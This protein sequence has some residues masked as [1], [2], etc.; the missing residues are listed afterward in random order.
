MYVAS[1]RVPKYDKQCKSTIDYSKLSREHSE[2]KIVKS[3]SHQGDVS[4]ARAMK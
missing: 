3:F 2:L 1:V 4:K